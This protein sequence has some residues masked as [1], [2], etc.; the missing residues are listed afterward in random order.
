MSV[1]ALFAPLCGGEVL[2]TDSTWRMRYEVASEIMYHG[3]DGALEADNRGTPIPGPEDSWKETDFDDSGWEMHTGPFFPG[4]NRPTGHGQG[5]EPRLTRIYLRGRFHVEDPSAVT[6]LGLA[7]RYRGG[8]VV[9]VNGREVGRSHVP[10]GELTS[11]TLASPYDMQATDPNPDNDERAAES[12]RRRL[13]ESGLLR[14]PTDAL[15]P[16]VNVIA[17]LGVRASIPTEANAKHTHR[18][19]WATTGI[20]EI[21][22]RA[23]PADGAR[24]HTG[25]LA[26]PQVWTAPMVADVGGDLRRGD[27]LEGIQPIRMIS[28]RNMTVSGQAVVSAP[29]KVTGLRAEIRAFSGPDGA[30][31]IPESAVRLRYPART[32]PEMG[33]EM[34]RPDVLLPEPL[35]QE[36]VQPIWITVTVPQDARPGAYEAELFVAADGLDPVRVPV[37]LLVH[38]WEAPDPQEWRSMVYMVQSP[39]SVAW[40]Y[41]VEMWSARHLELM[42]PS[43]QMMKKL[44][45]NVL[46]ADLITPSFFGPEHGVV[47]FREEGGRLVPDLTYFKAYLDAYARHVGEPRRVILNVWEPHVD[48]VRVSV[49]GEDG[50]LTHRELAPYGDAATRET[51]KTLMEEVR[52]DV[53]E[54]GWD[55][56]VISLGTGHDRRPPE[57]TVTF[58][59][60]IAPFARWVLFTHGRGDPPIR[61]GAVNMGGMEVGL[62]EYPYFARGRGGHLNNGRFGGQVNDWYE[63]MIIFAGR[64]ML[65]D[66]SPLRDFRLFPNAGVIGLSRGFTRQGIDKWPVVNPANPDEQARRRVHGSQGWGNLYRHK[67]RSIAAPGPEG[68][69]PTARFEQMREGLQDTEVRI[70][71]EQALNAGDLDEAIAEEIREINTTEWN[72]NG[73]RGNDWRFV[74]GPDW[75]RRVNRRLALAAEI[76][77]QQ[78]KE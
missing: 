35:G 38:D 21:T 62:Q 65:N 22:F 69:L 33:F 52:R 18:N 36:P 39:H 46:Y 15:R 71:L 10:D 9:Y 76:Q 14:L 3:A 77:R 11:E 2:R 48:R 73:S 7:L 20:Q 31:G 34:E 75:E 51:W 44:G 5:E 60:E 55:E 78:A 32:Y 29:G 1:F 12:A 50:R 72:L 58:F 47:V 49:R 53:L 19:R 4:P 57:R 40:R 23:R 16:G 37:R 25:D 42:G 64:L 74:P 27:P 70:F 30:G 24:G 41:G 13:R 56:R 59:N 26:A 43:L 68:A 6:D 8:V 54:R 28:G 61:D 66:N 67:V 63:S 17:I 45:N